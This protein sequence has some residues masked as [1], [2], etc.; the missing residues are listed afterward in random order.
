MVQ[1]ATCPLCE[2]SCGILVDTDGEHIR[3]IHGDQ[4]HDRNG[5]R[6]GVASEHAGVSMNDVTSHLHLDTLSGTA[7]FNGLAVTLRRADN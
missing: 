2:A 6:L 4:G 7:A 5:T 1:T 3:S